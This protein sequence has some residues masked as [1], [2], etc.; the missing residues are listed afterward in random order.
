MLPDVVMEFMPG[1]KLM[2]CAVVSLQTGDLKLQDRN[3]ALLVLGQWEIFSFVFTLLQRS[4][5]HSSSAVEVGYI[6]FSYNVK[7]MDAMSLCPH[8]AP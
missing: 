2:V 7:P 1:K 3:R 6:V 8:W 4:K 5:T